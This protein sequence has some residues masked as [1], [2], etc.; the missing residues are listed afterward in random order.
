[1]RAAGLHRLGRRKVLRELGDG[2]EVLVV[3]VAASDK[4]AT[5]RNRP[6]EEPR[7]RAIPGVA[8]QFVHALVADELR[9]L[10]VGMQPVERIA[11][12]GQRIEHPVVCEAPR[13]AE[14]LRFT[15]E[16]A[17]V[18]EYL[19]HAAVLRVEHVLHHVVTHSTRGVPRPFRERDEHRQCA[20]RCGVNVRVAQAG[21]DLVHGVPRHTGKGAAGHRILE[22]LRTIGKRAHEPVAARLLARAQL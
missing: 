18:G 17:D 5:F 22:W 11:P 6:I 19:G 12:L 10:R 14:V 8:T 21:E 2:E 4:R 15:S 13:E 9:H 7:G 3:A 1:M 20:R 16:H